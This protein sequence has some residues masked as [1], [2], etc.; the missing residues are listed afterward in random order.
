MPITETVD[1][2]S[3]RSKIPV[4]VREV[5]SGLDEIE[6]NRHK[7]VQEKLESRPRQLT[8]LLA[9]G[10]DKQDFDPYMVIKGLNP[11]DSE[12]EIQ[13]MMKNKD[14]LENLKL[15]YY[16]DHPHIETN[17]EFVNYLNSQDY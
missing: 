2:V 5:P 1:R 17:A 4:G 8:K 14:Y 10:T 15:E 13:S 12:V 6:A 9:N 3:V 7:R 16:L 11:Y